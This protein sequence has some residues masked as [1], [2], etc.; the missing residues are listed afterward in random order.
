MLKGFRNVTTMAA[1]A[2]MEI[3][4]PYGRGIEVYRTT[5]RNIREGISHVIKN[6]GIE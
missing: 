4:D 3:A 1:L 6:L 2:G 5:L